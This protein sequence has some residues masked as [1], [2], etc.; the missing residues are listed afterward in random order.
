MRLIRVA[1]V[2]MAVWGGLA[3]CN[4]EGG[5]SGGWFGFRNLG[6]RADSSVANR[7]R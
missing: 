7:A 1:V 2:L 3:G 5:D 4:S 6:K